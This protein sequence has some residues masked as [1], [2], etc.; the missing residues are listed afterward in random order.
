MN[1]Q[2]DQ[3]SGFP[4]PGTV[5]LRLQESVAVGLGAGTYSATVALSSS[6][7]STATI[8]V[9]YVVNSGTAAGVT[10]SP[11][12]TFAFPAVALGT[13]VSESQQFTV[14]AAAGT[15]LGSPNISSQSNPGNWL[16]ISTQSATS[17]QVLFTAT[18]ATAGLAAG[19]YSGN[20]TI[21]ATD[22]GE[23]ARRWWW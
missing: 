23:R 15:S 8:N 18:A 5:D 21:P 11:S 2:P 6:D 19:S 20:I 14:T 3:F 16:S 17:S 12:T 13:G 4:L 1:F 10:V 9:T 7:G 22:R